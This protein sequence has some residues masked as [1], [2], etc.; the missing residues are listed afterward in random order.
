VNGHFT[1]HIFTI[2]TKVTNDT[3]KF[4]IY[5]NLYF[6]LKIN[7]VDQTL[8]LIAKRNGVTA[9]DA[10]AQLEIYLKLLRELDLKSSDD[11]LKR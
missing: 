9:T 11:I 5:Y 2:I 6:Q 3:V 1:T 10:H 8:W 4:M 7:Q